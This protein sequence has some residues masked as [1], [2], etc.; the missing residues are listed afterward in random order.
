MEILFLIL[1]VIGI[2]FVVL[3]LLIFAVLAV[4]V[5]Y[6]IR[7]EAQDDITGKAVFSWLCRLLYLKIE[8]KEKGIACRLRI[9][10]F[11][12]SLNR[13]KKKRS[14]KPKR[15]K[16]EISHVGAE[17]TVQKEDELSSPTVSRDQ[18][19]TAAETVKNKKTGRKRNIFREWQEKIRTSFAMLE[20]WFSD[21][22]DKSTTGKEKIQNIKNLISE[23]TN[24]SAF[25]HFVKEMKFLIRHY[26]PRKASGEIA[27]GLQDP[28]QTG[29]ILG[30]L[31]LLPFWSRYQIHIMPDFL[32]EEFYAKGSLQIKGHI[33][34]WH[35]TWSVFR[36]IKDKNIRALITSF[37]T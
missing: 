24:K 26:S 11:P 19:F 28:S 15:Q 14:K 2:L 8:Y 37:R 1:K 27:F 7:M 5:R 3:L 18:N 31:S 34:T 12:V 30:M 6:S 35:M 13:Q 10:F 33:R 9:L 17:E 23:E 4:P 25:L 29:Q 20:K 16:A 36:L 32:T 21:L 22:K